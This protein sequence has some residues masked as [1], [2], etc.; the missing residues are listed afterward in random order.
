MTDPMQALKPWWDTAANDTPFE[1]VD[2][3]AR[4]FRYAT[5]H[6]RCPKRKHTFTRPLRAMMD[7]PQCPTC[8]RK[9]D[10]LASEHPRV[11]RRWHPS[12]N[13]GLLPRD[14]PADFGDDVWW[15]CER[16][17]AFKRSPRAMVKDDACPKCELEQTSLERV[18][19]RLALMWH[20]D[21]NAGTRPTDIPAQ[22][23]MPAWWVCPK[24]HEFTRQVNSMVNGDGACPVC[25]KGW[26]VDRIKDFVRSL[27]DNIDALDPSEIFSLAMQAGAFKSGAAHRF[28][29][30]VSSGKLPKSELQRFVDD[31]PSAVE[32]MVHDGEFSLEQQPDIMEPL[33]EADPW[34]LPGDASA[35]TSQRAIGLQADALS[36]ASEVADGEG[37]QDKEP[38]L[39]VVQTKD[40]LKALSKFA[41]NADDETVRFLIDSA[42]AK[43]WRHAYI[44]EA[45]AHNQAEVFDGQDAYSRLVREDFL[46]QLKAA[47]ELAL[48][49]GYAFRA[50]PGG[51]VLPPSLMQRHVA[52]CV[53]EKRHFGNFSGMG[54]G[55]TH[56]ANLSTR[57]V[58]AQMTV[59]CCPNS[60]V[61]NWAREIPNS[62][63][64]VQVRTKTWSPTW[65]PGGGP[66]YLVLNYEMFQQ[67]DSEARMVG[68]LDEHAVDFIVI[69]EIHFAKQRSPSAMS[70]RKRLVQ[71]MRLE[72]QKATPGLYVLGMSG[73]PV[74]NELQEGKSLVE[75]ITGRRHDDLQTKATVQNCMRL[76][77]K[78]VT[79]GTRWQPDYPMALDESNKPMV[80]CS[81]Y[82]DEIRRISASKGSALEIERVLTQARLPAIVEA[83]ERGQKTLVYTYYVDGIVKAIRLALEAK[84]LRVGAYT[85]STD[86]SD[87]RDF[88]DPQGQCEVLIASSRISTGVDGLQRVCAKLVVNVLPWTR[89]EYDQLRGRLWR[90]GSAFDRIDVV[91]PVTYADLT[92][93]R[94]SY[95]QSKLDRLE[96]KKSIADAAVD[97]RIPEGTLRTPAQAQRDILSWLEKLEGGAMAEISRPMIKI[98]LSGAPAD[99]A[100]RKSR[101]GDFTRL[102]NTWYSS[103]SDKTHR[104]LQQNPEEWGHYHTMYRKLRA[105]WDVVPYEEEIT[106][107]DK[108]EGKIL[109]DFGCGEALIAK[110]LGDKHRVLSFD[111]VAIDDDVVACDIRQVPVL[112]SELDGAVFCLSLMGANITDYIREAHRC[113]KI[114]GQLRIW[115]GANRMK[116]PQ[117]FAK[118]LEALGFDRTNISTKGGFV[119]VLAFKNADE[120]RDVTL[121]LTHTE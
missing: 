67:S 46:R 15:A 79:W 85:G 82:L 5:L 66:R 53:R 72:A 100:K 57:L 43:L 19:P 74:I 44:N 106:F 31:Q 41:A 81:E 25:Y 95:C 97:G 89:A 80:D 77:Q 28:A 86:D 30:A 8:A 12:A 48:P 35:L 56:S 76:Y 78:F 39:P 69:D 114:D 54:A 112:D 119:L 68:F 108:R 49:E 18:R 32:Q 111:H 103:N 17:H 87:L 113:L 121:S 91:T 52:V 37:G 62:F 104:R 7:Q 99:V 36:E 115:E 29:L 16:A 11:A 64:G 42:L 27:L 98:P 71:G 116:D 65:T 84:G 2:P 10:S 93:G 105:G 21:K 94:W 3:R 73:T 40:A 23:A 38:Q 50:D 83:C 92:G 70:R 47:R 13:D 118:T 110:A 45:E 34:A 9:G 101:Y 24:G 109:G 96:Y 60:V 4:A 59:V 33:K 51:P 1:D 61:D 120:P 75:L 90:Q 20:P 63:E 117:A 107:W 88:L 14:I 6:W 55:K 22:S 102:N 26:S 58:G